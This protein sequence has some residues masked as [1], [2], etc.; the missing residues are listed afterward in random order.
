MYPT[1][2]AWQA[3]LTAFIYIYFFYK[4]EPVYLRYG[5]IVTTTKACLLCAIP[6]G[7]YRVQSPGFLKRVYTAKVNAEIS[8]LK[9]F[10]IIT[11]VMIVLKHFLSLPL[12]LLTIARLPKKVNKPARNLGI[13]A[14]VRDL[15]S[16]RWELLIAMEGPKIEDT[17]SSADVVVSV[18]SVMFGCRHL[19]LS[20]CLSVSLKTLRLQYVSSERCLRRLIFASSYKHKGTMCQCVYPP[21]VLCV[22]SSVCVISLALVRIS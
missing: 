18:F 1:K 3:F 7:T 13:T 2:S 19:C 17:K 10:F 9:I 14:I 5:L 4:P 12:S 8:D 21:L 15:T 20:V 6:A 22:C 11:V 16:T